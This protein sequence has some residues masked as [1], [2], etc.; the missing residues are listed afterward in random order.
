MQNRVRAFFAL[1]TTNL[2]TSHRDPP[3]PAQ[4]KSS[5]PSPTASN[6]GAPASTTSQNTVLERALA[7]QLQK[8]PEAEK[9]AFVQAAKTIDERT[10][11]YDVQTYDV[12]HKEN[13]S[14]RPHAERLSKFLGLLDRFMGGVAIGIQASP[15]VS[16]LVVG[17]VRIVIDLALKFTTFF[18]RLTE[19]VCIF[20]DYLG[21]LAKYAGGADIE[22]VET[23]V[24]NAYE[25]VLDFGWKARRVFVDD[26]GNQRR[27]TSFRTF[28][29]QHWETFEFDFVSIREHMQ[30][31]LNVLLHS[32]QALHFDAFREAE[33]ARRHEE[34]SRSILSDATYVYV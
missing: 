25:N 4:Q 26:N 2:A 21:P 9:A 31:H 10:L 1:D 18:G 23:T 12:A 24:V 34:E 20:A 6:G 28:M 30:H 29:R 14:F 11:L 27:W 5:P 15:E 32:V 8:I 3:P 13:S 17:A 7:K 33:Q 22:L 16:S 19:M